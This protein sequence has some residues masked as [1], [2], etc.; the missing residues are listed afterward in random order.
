MQ[1]ERNKKITVHIHIYV[2]NIFQYFEFLISYELKDLNI[3]K[4][5][6]LIKWTRKPE[7]MFAPSYSNHY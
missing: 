5:N 3:Y 4:Y 1:I 7:I 6:A 2:S